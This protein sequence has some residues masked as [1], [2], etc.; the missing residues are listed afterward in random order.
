MVLARSKSLFLQVNKLPLNSTYRNLCCFI[1]DTNFQNQGTLGQPSLHL[2]LGILQRFQA[3]SGFEFIPA[4]KENAHPPQ[5][6]V[7]QSV[8]A[9]VAEPGNFRE[10]INRRLEEGKFHG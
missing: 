4:P 10:N 8:G 5:P 9:P 2:R 1:M 3:F 7:T 6:R